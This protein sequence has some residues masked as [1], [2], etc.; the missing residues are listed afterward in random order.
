[1]ECSEFKSMGSAVVDVI[2]RFFITAQAGNLLLGQQIEHYEHN[3]TI[4]A[5]LLHI[6]DPP[7]V[8]LL[9]LLI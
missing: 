1:M 5:K 3:R 2:N 6:Y 9:V 4:E 7:V 8:F